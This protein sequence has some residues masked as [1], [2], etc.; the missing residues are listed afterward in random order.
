M[1][2]I[3]CIRLIKKGTKETI[4]IQGVLIIKNTKREKEIL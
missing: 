4:L 2:K 3:I 1:N